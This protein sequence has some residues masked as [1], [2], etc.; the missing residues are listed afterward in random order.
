MKIKEIN[1][2]DKYRT[3]RKTETG[4]TGEWNGMW[5]LYF[6]PADQPSGYLAVDSAWV[7]TPGGSPKK[8]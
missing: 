7:Y 2:D 1:N 5:K 8:R 3:Y 6:L 4:K